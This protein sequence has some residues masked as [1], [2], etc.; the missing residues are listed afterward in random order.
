MGTII[1]IS[2]LLVIASVFYYTFKKPFVP[3][4]IDDSKPL[5][6]VDSDFDVTYYHWDG[7]N[8]IP[9][10]YNKKNL[11]QEE[12]TPPSLTMTC[13]VYSFDFFVSDGFNMLFKTTNIMR[14]WEERYKQ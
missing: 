9:K 7:K 3:L 2:V 1:L 11:F 6:I 5:F 4:P 12:Q 8:V 13:M 14:L 10:Q